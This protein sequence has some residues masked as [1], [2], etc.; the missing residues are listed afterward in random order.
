MAIERVVLAAAA[1]AGKVAEELA[2]EAAQACMGIVNAA[3]KSITDFIPAE[4]RQGAH[5]GST[6]GIYEI[7]APAHTQVLRGRAFEAASKSPYES[8]FTGA[9]PE[10]TGKIST[11]TLVVGAG[12]NGLS[13]AETFAAHGIKTTLVDAGTIGSLT[14]AR[15]TGIATRAGDATTELIDTLGPKTFE[16]YAKGMWNAKNEVI[17]RA[18]KFGDNIDFRRA[19]SRQ[20]SYDAG[21]ADDWML[22]EYDGFRQ[23][24][25]ELSFATGDEAASI[26]E[27]AK[28]VMTF[29]NEAHFNPRKYLGEMARN[30][31]YDI[32]ENSEVYA[33]ELGKAGQAVTAL[34]K[35]GGRIEAN[36]VIFA[37][38]TGGHFLPHLDKYVEPVQ[39]FATLVKTK[40]PVK[41]NGSFF[42]DVG[43]ELAP[44][45]MIRNRSVEGPYTYFREFPSPNGD[46]ILFGGADKMLSEVPATRS[47]SL[48]KKQLEMLFP[49]STIKREW[50]GL[51]DEGRYGMSIIDSHPYIPQLIGTRATGGSGLVTSQLNARELLNYVRGGGSFLS[52]SNQG[53]R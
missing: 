24:D 52:A 27:H 34:T 50:N 45:G 19:D 53:M 7:V 33:F 40:G 11:D 22:K 49:G 15:G 12:M 1:K 16:Q 51:L 8:S 46:H 14:S 25:K 26:F 2:P 39:C 20:I 43:P 13:I 6:N 18:A 44:N 42:D 9:F 4:L 32:F 48:V 10:V 30:A 35:N 37:T 31:N 17:D 36:N 29:R 38:G 47:A 5:I 23:F 21:A 41:L 28:A 3:R